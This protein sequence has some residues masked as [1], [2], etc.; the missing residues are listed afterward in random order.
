MEMTRGHP[1]SV[2]LGPVFCLG[3]VYG[4][5]NRKKGSI[6]VQNLGK[7]VIMDRKET[8]ISDGIRVRHH[9]GE[10]GVLLVQLLLRSTEKGW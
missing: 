8:S 2:I 5:E 6:A 10:I 1:G 7:S 4:R 9:R 3:G